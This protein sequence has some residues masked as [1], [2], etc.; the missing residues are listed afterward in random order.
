MII[1]RL[2]NDGLPQPLP[3]HAGPVPSRIRIWV[4]NDITGDTVLVRDLVL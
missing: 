1:E 4:W 3:P 2:D